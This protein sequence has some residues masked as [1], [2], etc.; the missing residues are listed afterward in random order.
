MPIE[1]AHV[2]MGSGA[3]LGQKPDDWRCVPLCGDHHRQQHSTSEPD[4]WLTYE[5]AASQTV[6]N[7]IDALIESSPKRFQIREQQREREQ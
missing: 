7:L 4:F 6:F 2:R 3:G 1:A 5:K